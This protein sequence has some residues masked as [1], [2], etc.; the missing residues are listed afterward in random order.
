MN[1]RHL[2]LVTTLLAAI[3]TTVVGCGR[4]TSEIPAAPESAAPAP[5]PAAAP[6]ASPAM[7]NSA[8]VKTNAP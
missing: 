2:I 5:P 7:T 1:T 4:N 3:A 6:A 8:T